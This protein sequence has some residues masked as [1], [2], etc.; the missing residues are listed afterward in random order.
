[1]GMGAGA[2]QPTSSG[3]NGIAPQPTAQPGA[4]GG[5]GSNVPTR[6]NTA[7]NPMGGKGGSSVTGG[8]PATNTSYP[9]YNP[10]QNTFG[11]LGSTNV[12]NPVSAN[13]QQ[14][15]FPQSTLQLPQGGFQPNYGMYQPQVMPQQ[16]GG[17][18]GG[19]QVLPGAMTLQQMQQGMQPFGGMPP[20]QNPYDPSSAPQVQKTLGGPLPTQQSPYAQPQVMPGT[21]GPGID[22]S[23]YINTGTYGSTQP[24]MMPQVMPQQG[25]TPGLVGTPGVPPGIQAYINSLQGTPAGQMPP[26]GLTPQQLSD[27][28]LKQQAMQ[29]GLSQTSPQSSPLQAVSQQLK[30]L[31]QNAGQMPQAPTQQQIA[32]PNQRELLQRMMQQFRP[33]MGQNKGMM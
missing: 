15:Q 9:A 13:N 25:G 5:M 18:F 6:T 4:K 21:G 22:M 24:G 29:G 2:G 20:Q 1:M 16:G 23:K 17:M 11:A 28:Q 19:Q 10:Q 27:F 32:Q 14:P 30:G 7:N 8:Q 31:P 3:M 12:Y 33:G 26:P